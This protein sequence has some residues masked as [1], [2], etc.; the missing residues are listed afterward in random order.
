MELKSSHETQNMNENS[1]DGQIASDFW[2]HYQY[3]KTIQGET[4]EGKKDKGFNLLYLFHRHTAQQFHRFGPADA[5]RAQD[6]KPVTKEATSQKVDPNF[7]LVTNKTIVREGFALVHHPPTPFPSLDLIRD[8]IRSDST[9]VGL[10]GEDLV[11]R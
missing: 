7:M 1:G 8:I 3:Y 4:S 6:E 9:V 5:G 2:K 10:E 11:D